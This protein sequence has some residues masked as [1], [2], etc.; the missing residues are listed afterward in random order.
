[1]PTI[2]SIHG[3]WY[4]G[5]IYSFTLWTLGPLI[6]CMCFYQKVLLK[7]LVKVWHTFGVHLLVLVL[8]ILFFMKYMYWYGL[9]FLKVLLTTLTFTPNVRCHLI[10]G[11]SAEKA[12]VAKAS[13]YNNT[14]SHFPS[15]STPTV[16]FSVTSELAVKGLHATHER[17]D[18]ITKVRRLFSSPLCVFTPRCTL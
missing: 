3:M 17:F 13:H 6:D 4:S 15:R 16:S 2:H 10:L 11:F 18:T 12:C 5:A 9:Y 7:V 1:M 8:P 14:R